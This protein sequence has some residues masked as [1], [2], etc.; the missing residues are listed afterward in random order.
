M[1]AAAAAVACAAVLFGAAPGGALAQAA[2][3]A[4]WLQKAYA[5]TRNLSFSGTFV[6]QQGGQSETSRITRIVEGELAREKLETLDGTPREVVRTGEQVLCYLPA[7]TTLRIDRQTGQPVFPGA[8]TGRLSDIA[9]NYTARKQAMDRVAGYDCQVIVLEPRDRMRYG[10][11]LWVE[12][13]TGMLLKAKTFDENGAVVEQF[14]FTQIQLGGTFA[15]ELLRSRFESAGK[16]WRVEDAQVI[17][18]DLSREGWQIREGVSGYRK[19]AE[20]TRT[21]GGIPGVGHIVLSDGLAAMS[22]F[23][24]PAKSRVLRSLPV[25]TRYGAISVYAR[26]LG[27]HRVT[28][29]GEA[30]LQGVRAIANAVEFRRPN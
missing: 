17:E 25:L 9:G 12:A 14:A 10:Q 24:E 13:Q 16:S 5:A 19:I 28:A 18:R 30:P 8:F 3:A 1:R 15:P 7:S 11:K 27:A 20:M 2:E 29:V 23:I 4:G 6:Y 21:L 26:Q 22:V